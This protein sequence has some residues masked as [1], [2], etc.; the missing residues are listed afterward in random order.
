[1]R[2]TNSALVLVFL[3][4]A[5]AAARGDAVDNPDKRAAFASL[6]IPRAVDMS[7]PQR[8]FVEKVGP[9]GKDLEGKEWLVI[10]TK[11][12]KI[13]YQNSID[14]T[15]L[16]QVARYV[17]NVY[18]FL[19]TWSPSAPEIPIKSF[20]VP[21]EE[22]NSRCF[23]YTNSMSTGDKGEV[24]M[25]I[26]SFLHEE[27]HLFNDAYIGKPGQGMWAG[28][29]T[30][31]YFQQRARQEAK[32]RDVKQYIKSVLPDGPKRSLGDI[33]SEGF[34][35]HNEA[36]SVMYFMHKTYGDESFYKFRVELLQQ[37]K[38]KNN[39][40]RDPEDIFIKATGKGFDKLNPEWR[41]YYGWDDLKKQ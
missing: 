7:K 29:F 22:G 20:L 33:A 27:A 16:R 24:R 39:S 41:K 14:Q 15:K 34:E 19:K 3:C 38:T 25:I 4:L 36:F 30:C 26:T 37:S 13:Y 8:E 11:Y 10:S 28:E 40:T 9:S 31:H 12:N 18:D 2:I 5:V 6:W 17:D 1:M 23:F 35:L 21:D 32:N